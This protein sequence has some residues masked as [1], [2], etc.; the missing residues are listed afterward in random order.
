MTSVVSARSFDLELTRCLVKECL[1]CV[2]SVPSLLW[3][4]SGVRI[5][6]SELLNCVVRL[7]VVSDLVSAVFV[8]RTVRLK[9]T[10][11]SWLWSVRV[12]LMT[13]KRI[14]L[15]AAGLVLV[16]VLLTWLTSCAWLHS[17]VVC[18]VGWE[19]AL[20]WCIVWVCWI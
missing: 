3:C 20:C 4:V 9:V 19:F 15:G 1:S 8:R 18:L 12:L 16:R 13:R 2:V 5:M 6:K 17:V 10:R 14:L 11:L 7:L